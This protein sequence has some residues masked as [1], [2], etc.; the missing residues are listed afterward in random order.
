[1]SEP[2]EEVIR[3][4]QEMIDKWNEHQNDYVRGEL[5]R[6]QSLLEHLTGQNFFPE[7]V[8]E[9][10]L[11]EFLFYVLL[12]DKFS[13]RRSAIVDFNLAAVQPG[14][15]RAK[16]CEIGHRKSPPIATLVTHLISR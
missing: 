3:K 8:D 14:R 16:W 15:R 12:N 2:D 1:M 11:L 10:H 7:D 5:D 13:V 9:R 4:S 6:N